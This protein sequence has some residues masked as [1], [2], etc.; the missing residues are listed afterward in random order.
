[1]ISDAEV[2]EVPYTAFAGTKAHA[3]VARLMRRVRRLAPPRQGELLPA[4]PTPWRGQRCSE[5][6][7]GDHCN[8]R[9]HL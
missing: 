2:A 7:A 3:V 6:R 8:E 4:W 9:G 5:R 1:M